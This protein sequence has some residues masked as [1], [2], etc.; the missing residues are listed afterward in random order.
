MRF[1][2]RLSRCGK[3]GTVSIGDACL[4]GLGP[5]RHRHELN[6]ACNH[7]ALIQLVGAVLAEQHDEW[8]EARRYSVSTCSPAPAVTAPPLAHTSR[9]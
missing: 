1:V 2:V 6:S 3:E 5:D 7:T 9:R 4:L 8:I